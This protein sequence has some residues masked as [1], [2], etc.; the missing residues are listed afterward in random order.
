[1]AADQLLSASD[2]DQIRLLDAFGSLI[3]NA[4]RHFGNVTLFDEYDGPFTLAPVYDM[5][6]MLFAPQNEQIVPRC[7]SLRLRD[8]AGVRMVAG[9]L[10]R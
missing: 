9:P 5:L 6:P 2:T 10:P 8:R 7:S 3:A 1:M 4:D